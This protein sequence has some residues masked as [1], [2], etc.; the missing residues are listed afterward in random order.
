MDTACDDV[1]TDEASVFDDETRRDLAGRARSLAARLRDPDAAV[2]AE[3]DGPDADAALSAWRESVGGEA[4]FQTRLDRLGLD[5]ATCRR[6]IRRR[7]LAP[8]EPLPD[9]IA[10]VE[11]LAAHVADT[12]PATLPTRLDEETPD[13]GPTTLPGDGDRWFGRLSAAVAT[14]ARERL[15]A[16]DTAA[17][18]FDRSSLGPAA[19]WLRLR[20]QHHFVRPLYV[21]AKTFVARRDRARAFADPDDVDDPPTEHYE[22]FVA[23]LFDGGF[24]DCCLEYPV[25]ARLLATQVRQWCTQFRELAT[26]I[27]TDREALAETF[28]GTVEGDADGADGTGTEPGAEG[29]GDGDAFGRVLA[30]RPL[31]DDTH[32][33]GRAVTAVTFASGT[34]DASTVVY[35]PRSVEPEAAFAELLD[36]LDDTLP[37]PS[38]RTPTHRSRDGYGWVSWVDADECTD[39]AAVDRYYRRA[40]RLAAV[41]YLLEFTDC[42]SENLLVAGEHPVL[43]DAETLGHPHVRVGRRPRRRSMAP[44]ETDSVLYTTLLPF[45]VANSAVGE[46]SVAT[47]GIGVSDEAT[48]LSDVTEPRVRAHGTDVMRVDETPVT[49]ESDT[50]LPTVDGEPRHPSDYLDALVDGFETAY[51]HLSAAHTGESVSGDSPTADTSSGRSGDSPTADTSDTASLS[52]L[53]EAVSGFDT[54]VLY[55]PTVRYAS[56]LRSLSARDCLR[57]GARFGATVEELAAPLCDDCVDDPVP[58]GIYEAERRA[59]WRLDPPRLT[60]PAG[61]T[62]VHHDGEPLDASVDTAGVDRVRD[63]LA[64]ACPAD[65][66]EQVELLRASFGASPSD[67]STRVRATDT[68]PR[69]VSDERLRETASRLFDRVLSA[70][71]VGPDGVPHWS[72]PA[73]TGERDRLTLRPTDESLYAGR[74]GVAVFAA[75]LARVR[76]D[77]R[78]E[79]VATAALEPIR[80]R[81]GS[82]EVPP[83]VTD[84]GGTRGLGGVVYGL[85]VVGDLLDDATVIDDA[86]AAVDAVGLADHGALDTPTPGADAG[87]PRDGTLGGSADTA[88][89]G[90]LADTPLAAPE[91]VDAT[92]GLA[93]TLS[94]LLGLYE[95]RS[96]PRVLAAAR[97]CGE[98][99]LD[100]RVAAPDG[101]PVWD[102]GRGDRPLLGFAHGLAGVTYPL[103]RLSAATDD[104]RFRRAALPA[105][106][107]E[108]AAYDETAANWPDRR[109]VGSAFPDR[110]CHGRTGIGLARLAAARYADDEPV[111]RDATRAVEGS[112]GTGLAGVDNLCCGTAG[113]ASLRLAAARAD[114]LPAATRGAADGT[115]RRLL[116]GTLARA[117]AVGAYSLPAETDAVTV[118]SLFDGLAGIGYAALRVTAPDTLPSLLSWA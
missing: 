31:A 85:A 109:A 63:R 9:W 92:D 93:G 88:D 81:I 79:T 87:E 8:D 3:T 69:P 61:E 11:A 21:E 49:V 115:A 45:D 62:T 101:T 102:T 67:V 52:D 96:D 91:S 54:R 78:A 76:D 94:G 4:A 84:H 32:H 57:S 38:F 70:G 35:K 60:V 48:V 108:S 71:T 1:T 116:G 6:R 83:S 28:G 97:R 103:V 64:A 43:V 56:L 16:D 58:W 47:A 89:D 18:V 42:Q 50:T 59:L 30:V 105:L 29:A 33:D 114:A 2:P 51:D 24:V 112:L 39:E 68:E 40:G 107:Y 34:D 86:I 117:D 10:T 72:S 82:E 106:R 44:F 5:E 111:V 23:D 104:P 74:L 15:L 13:A 19:E 37:S 36:R 90:P 53:S 113:R 25:M 110:W 73:P 100:R 22:A 12:D 98:A 14:F 41:A 65:R 46:L 80:T 27:E 77:R 75:A 20:F 66:R 55:R 118:P 99:L 17:A 26:R 7:R 95:R